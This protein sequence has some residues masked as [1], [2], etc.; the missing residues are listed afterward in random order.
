[1]KLFAAL[2]CA[3]G[4]ITAPAAD[5]FRPDQLKKESGEIT[6][7]DQSGRKAIRLG[8]KTGTNSGNSAQYRTGSIVFAEPVDLTGKQLRF[9]ASST[10]PD[11]LLALYI[12]AY[13]Q[14]ETK[15]VWSALNYANP[16]AGGEIECIVRPDAKGVLNWEPGAVSGAAPAKVNRIQFWLGSRSENA[17]LEAKFYDFVIE[18]ANTAAPVAAKPQCKPLSEA[19]ALQE[20]FKAAN[21]SCAGGKLEVI[22]LDG[23]KALKLSAVTKAQKSTYY[24]TGR[25]KLP[26]PLDLAGRQLKF[27]VTTVTPDPVIALVARFYNLGDSAKPVW[28]FTSWGKVFAAGP[29]IGA[30][31]SADRG[32]GLPWEEKRVSGAVADRVDLVEFWLGSTVPDVP[33]E[34]VFSDFEFAKA[35]AAPTKWT[36]VTPYADAPAKVAHPVGSVKQADIERARENLKRYDWAKESY[37]A[38]KKR[39]DQWMALDQ[40]GIENMVPAGDAFFK[41]LCPNCGTQPEFAWAGNVLQPDGKSIQCTKCKMIFPNDKYPENKTYTVSTP[42]GKVKTIKYFEGPDQIA[43]GENYGKKYHLTGAVNYVKIRQIGTIY[44][45][46]FVYAMTG[47]KAYAQKVRDVLVRFADVYPDY[48]VKFRATIYDSPKANSMGG[49]LCAWKFHDSTIL[50]SVLNAY[51]M[52]CNSGVYSDADKL[53]IENG[54]CREYKNLITAW[55]PTKDWCLNAVPAHMTTAA[56]CAAITGDHELMDWVLKGP[57]GFYSFV[58]KYYTRDGHWYESAPSYANMANDP[59]VTLVAAL[60]GYS[61]APDY[62]GDDRYD[63][64]DIFKATPALELVFTGMANG[65]LPT[66]YL[67]A[68]NDSAFNSRQSISQLELVAALRPTP[69]NRARLTYFAQNFPV[70]WGRELSLLY[71]DPELKLDAGA[72][73][74]E[75]LRRS[76][77]APGG[78]VAVLRRPASAQTSALAMYTGGDVGGH[79][80]NSTL[81]YLYCDFAKEVISDLGYLS[82]W[83]DHRT[84]NNSTLAHNVV[85][86]DGK[87]QDKARRGVPELFASSDKGIAAMRFD[88]AN[89]YPG[90]TGRYTRALYNIPL[91]TGGQYVIDVFTV[92]GGASHLWNFHADGESMKLDRALDFKPVDMLKIADKATGADWLKNAGGA[93]FGPG[94]LRADWTFNPEITTR[95]WLLA[96]KPLEVI[97]AEAPG[98]R[99]QKTPYLKVPLHILLARAEGPENRFVSVFESAKG[100]QFAVNSAELLPAKEGG[101]EIKVTLSDGAYDLVSIA[102]SGKQSAIRRFAGGKE[103]SSWSEGGNLLTGKITAIDVDKKELTTSLAALPAGSDFKHVY[104]LIP[105]E[106]DGVYQLDGAEIRGGK[107]VFKLAPKEVIRLKTG[108]EFVINQPIEK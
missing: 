44:S 2:L 47:D 105:S 79:S 65:T 83:H 98:L 7:I 82:W 48:S 56:L 81:G 102:A 90:V 66:G 42:R 43:Q 55:P 1:M 16:F 78:G 22:E 9:K 53:K 19:D 26:A 71:R 52:T 18:D 68:F 103:I 107:V 97:K 28:S 41:C 88:A 64:L 91:P 57:D 49:K 58:D 96:E 24:A 45:A 20:F 21:L 94:V 74:P 92:R 100:G 80:H 87:I 77:I 73:M 32:V 46:A 67:P 108:V 54:I 35:P 11:A 72:P 33:L 23:K 37:D 106:K 51:S 40:K 93:K 14:G 95:M 99:D 38:V 34:A 86:V 84:W 62:Q 70:T 36:P 12:R 75:E 89:A 17:P 29:V 76:F 15:P 101:L 8:G 59:M 104:M 4:I 50:P 25:I 13:N 61:D 63:K 27:K 85:V 31:L 10:T 6:V 3:G 69:E 60:Q 5:F 39:A 30:E